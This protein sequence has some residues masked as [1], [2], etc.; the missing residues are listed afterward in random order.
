MNEQETMNTTAGA[1]VPMPPQYAPYTPYTVPERVKAEITE[2]DR[3]AALIALLTGFLGIR[4]AAIPFMEN[5]RFGLGLSIFLITACG[6][7]FFYSKDRSRSHIIRLAVA[8]A[9]SLNVF[10][11]G[12]ELMQLLS[13]VF[14]AMVICLD[15]LLVCEGFGGRVRNSLFIDFLRSVFEP[16]G[17]IFLIDEAFKPKKG[18]GKII[19][20]VVIGL[21][22]AFVPTV[23]AASLLSEAD[24]RFSEIISVIMDNS[25]EHILKLGIS[26]VFGIPVGVYIFSVVWCGRSRGFDS[27]AGADPAADRGF[28]APMTGVISVVPVLILYLIFFFSQLSYY[29]S[30]FANI[31]PHSA[32]SYSEYAREGFFE[33]CGVVVLNLVILIVLNLTSKHTD[34]DVHRSVKAVSIVL[35]L[36]TLALIATAMRKMILYISVYG[37]S[38]LRIYTSWFMVLLALLFAEM[39]IFF[40]RKYNFARAFSVTFTLMLALLV[41]SHPDHLTAEYNLSA[42]ANGDLPHYK[43][44]Q[45]E[46]LSI[47]C[48]PAVRKHSQ[49]IEEKTG[50]DADEVIRRINKDRV[51]DIFTMCAG[52]LINRE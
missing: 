31:L 5:T 22:I 35:S 19:S 28:I 8:A 24:S 21:L 46:E 16:L 2:T 29:V 13:A 33:L 44:T 27:K 9:F 4:C 20:S 48:I 49:V 7:S 38:A 39:M 3:K 42:Y 43:I 23:M 51:Q 12:N 32:Q 37:L 52:D 40:F 10:L 14:A 25:F 36:F 1:G 6:F 41:F 50:K 17:K 26:A 15:S 34:G 11:T 18:I 45:L 47:D 30:A